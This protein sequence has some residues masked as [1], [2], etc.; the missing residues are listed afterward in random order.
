MKRDIMIMSTIRTAKQALR[1]EIKKKVAT[2]SEQNKA[3]QSFLV[4][5]KVIAHPSY[6]N[7]QRIAVFLSM[8]D[9]VQTEGIIKHAFQSGKQ[10]FIPRYMARSHHMDMVKLASIEEIKS[11]PLTTW[12]I[13][14]PAFED[15]REEALA[16]G[17]LDLVLMPGLAFDKN[18]N[19]LGRGK[20]YYDVYLQ[21]CLQHPNGKPYTLA[22]AFKEQICDS[23][24]VGE[25]DIQID[26][27]LHGGE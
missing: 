13:H 5:E 16:S 25:S 23:V 7:A 15:T 20:G 6:Q 10:C 22:L 21:R 9:E 26:D 4:T 3:R 11:L 24:P 8:Q 14:Q 18:G 27:V 17:G 2:L 19:R 12:N 1:E